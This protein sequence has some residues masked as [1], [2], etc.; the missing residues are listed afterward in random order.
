MPKRSEPAAAEGAKGIR[1][2]ASP[3]AR[4]TATQMSVD[5]AR[6]EGSGPGGR[7]I[8]EDVFTAAKAKASGPVPVRTMPETESELIPL[9]PMRRVIAQRMVES[10]TTTPHFYLT[11]ELDVAKL[12]ELRAEANESL[13]A[14]KSGKL[15][16]NDF[17]LKACVECL[18]RV[19]QLNSSF[20]PE[21][22]LRFTQVHLGFA[23]SLDEGLI[24]PVLRNAERKTLRQL[25]TEAREMT[26]RARAKKLKPEE[27]QGGTF[28]IT[29]LGASGIDSFQA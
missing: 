18:Q 14:T 4:K 24:T 22:I 23:V 1:V 7:I 2:K 20:T 25:S 15:S 13:A 16:I 28:T 9:S 11:V 10:K 6:I 12:L 26:E 5:L 17:V 27:Y 19:P 3:L 8:Q 29:N 21:G